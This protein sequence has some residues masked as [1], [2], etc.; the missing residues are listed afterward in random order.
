MRLLLWLQLLTMFS[1][2]YCKNYVLAID[3]QARSAMIYHVGRGVV[4]R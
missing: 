3:Y 1:N 4:P 2:E